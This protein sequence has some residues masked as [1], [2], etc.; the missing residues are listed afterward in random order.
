MTS[1]TFNDTKK[2]GMQEETQ[3]TTNDVAPNQMTVQVFHQQ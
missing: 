2:E 3:S 1:T